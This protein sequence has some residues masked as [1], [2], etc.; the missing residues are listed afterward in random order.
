MPGGLQVPQC[1]THSGAW[2]WVGARAGAVPREGSGESQPGTACQPP[3]ACRLG[4][5][6]W[7]A[8]AKEP[9]VFPIAAQPQFCP[10]PLP[11]PP[12][13]SRGLLELGP[14]G[15]LRA[16]WSSDRDFIREP[17]V[18]GSSD[19]GKITPA[20]AS[21]ASRPPSTPRPGANAGAPHGAY[22]R[23]AGCRAW[24]ARGPE[25]WGFPRTP[26]LFFRPKSNPH[27]CLTPVPRALAPSSLRLP[28]HLRQ[29]APRCETLR[30]SAWPAG[31]GDKC[32]DWGACPFPGREKVAR[33][34]SRCPARPDLLP[35]FRTPD[36]RGSRG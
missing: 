34:G 27:L 24:G 10:C 35:G 30:S 33:G 22:P 17:S 13:R 31:P 4:A 9:L 36:L 2:R 11:Q 18:F 1:W 8:V 25:G 6:P 28:D 5:R 16:R 3:C 21:C 15:A 19:L 12:A 20:V 32:S 7:G 23:L 26:S 29:R 14:R